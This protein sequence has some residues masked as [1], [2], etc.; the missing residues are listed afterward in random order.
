[1]NTV[2]TGV[3]VGVGKGQGKQWMY[4]RRKLEFGLIR[5]VGYGG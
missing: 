1:M 2:W 3:V 5:L 4:A